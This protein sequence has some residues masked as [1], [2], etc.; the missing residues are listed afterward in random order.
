MATSRLKIVAAG[1]RKKEARMPKFVLVDNSLAPAGGHHFDFTEAILGE[2]ERAGFEPIIASNVELAEDVEFARRW[3][4]YRVFPGTIY[5]EYNLF[6]FFQWEDRE[7][8]KKAV[9]F[10]GLLKPVS[11]CINDV[12]TSLR[13][14]RWP[15]KRA[16]R[17]QGFLDACHKLFGQISLAP[18]DIVLLPTVSDLELEM[19]GRLFREKP[20]TSVAQWHLY[21]HNNFLTGRPHE[22]DRQRFQLA[23]MQK[24]MQSCLQGA[25]NHD[26]RFYATTEQLLDQFQ[27][28]SGGPQFSLLTYP[29]RTALR[30]VVEERADG[31]KQVVCAG[32]FRD[33]R[34]QFALPEIVRAIWDD[35]LKPARAQIHV[36]RDKPDWQVALPEEASSCAPP[37][38]PVVYHPHPLATEDY[39]R[40]MREA[41]I[42]L[43]LHDARMYYQRLSGVF[44]E[45]RCAGIPTIVPAGCWLGEQVAE[46]NFQHVD[47]TLRD[48]KKQIVAHAPP[49]WTNE[50]NFL[51][52]LVRSKFSFRGKQSPLAAEIEIPRDGSEL[53][54]QWQWLAPLQFG[55]YARLSLQRPDGSGKWHREAQVVLGS[56]KSASDIGTIFHIRPEWRRVK[57]VFENAFAAT[58]IC[59]SDPK[60][61]FLAVQAGQAGLPTGNSGLSFA[62]RSEIPRLLREMLAHYRHY[63]ERAREKSKEWIDRLTPKVTLAQLRS[64][65]AN[66]PAANSS[67]AA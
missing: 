10:P 64:A 59:I 56:R 40:M 29:A 5:H 58:P 27:R 36:Q 16:I 41:D 34:G 32:G 17:S 35:L 48:W 51:A 12:R 33:E 57:L 22:Y 45:Y 2:A 7:A 3:K 31:P 4:T 11:N 30:N 66:I 37:A 14:K 38:S 50:R 9:T 28:L 13:R 19:L 39:N 60:I 44:Q 21:F 62:E 24:C 43:L 42:G 67:R 23:T 1:D 8:K 25:K 61:T 20:E 65:P 6:Y 18:G 46:E 47:Q 55:Q 15:V 53:I 49:K 54:V 63:R 52:R 26:I